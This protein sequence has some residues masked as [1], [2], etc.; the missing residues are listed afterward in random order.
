MKNRELLTKIS[1]I[2]REIETKFPEVYE[3]LDEIPQTIPSK[4]NPEV[5][6]QDL[7]NYLDSLQTILDK[8]KKNQK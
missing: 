5:E 8:A 3:H 1:T 7:E 6:K 2:T 4:E